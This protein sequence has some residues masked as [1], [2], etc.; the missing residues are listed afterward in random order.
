[1]SDFTQIKCCDCGILID[2]GIHSS[3]R[4]INCLKPKI[5]EELKNG[6][7]LDN[8]GDL[9]EITQCNECKRFQHFNGKW[10]HH[11]WE[12]PGL[13]NMLLKY[14]HLEQ[15]EVK[16]VDASFVYTEE[17]SRRIKI[18]ITFDR[19]VLDGTLD[20]RSNCL[21]EFKQKIK[22]CPD[23]QRDHNPHNWGACLQLRQRKVGHT[24]NLLHLE[25]QINKS[26]LTD[27]ISEFQVVKD[28]FDAYFQNKNQCKIVTEF[29]ESMLPCQKKQ[30][31]KKFK[32]H[33]ENVIV[34]EV[35]PYSRY[36]LVIDQSGDKRVYI[37]EKLA[38]TLHLVDPCTA[39]RKEIP[40]A[41]ALNA[42]SAPIVL[43]SAKDLLPFM[44]LDIESQ[45]QDHEAYNHNGIDSNAHV[46]SSSSS[47]TTLQKRGGTFA[48]EVQVAQEDD[49]ETIHSVP[50]HLGGV[51]HA[52]DFVLAYDLARINPS[53]EIQKLLD[54]A[55]GTDDNNSSSSGR[56]RLK[57][58]TKNNKI[59]TRARGLQD[60]IVTRKH[61]PDYIKEQMKM[62]KNKN[63]NKNNANKSKG[64]NKEKAK[65]RDLEDEIQDLDVYQLEDFDDEAFLQEMQ[66]TT[67][68]TTT[69]TPPPPTPT[70]PTENVDNVNY[71]SRKV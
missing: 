49:F 51:L 50:C 29:I 30:A 55:R 6:L 11:E 8:N 25:E 54:A 33:T 64:Q 4:C 27:L 57:N 67:T 17:H 14:L 40:A 18:N 32:T 58:K 13:L 56:G 63:K 24:R 65:E 12:S 70:T 66:T 38:S 19:A 7:K 44:V 39:I 52:G 37:V 42:K 10:I 31:V 53:D 60:I 69:T 2:P 5:N 35:A 41:K 9:K 34:M 20:V 1:M 61:Y 16:I 48:A 23:C 36:D 62:N 68:T 71:S 15:Q 46:S 43:L 22:M 59:K 26:N 21:A 28:G 3:Y 45:E 47:S